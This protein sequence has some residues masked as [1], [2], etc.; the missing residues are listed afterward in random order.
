MTHRVCVK[1]RSRDHSRIVDAECSASLKSPVSSEPT[2]AYACTRHIE[3]YYCAACSPREAMQY[4][5]LVDIQ[6]NNFAGGVDS[7]RVGTLKVGRAHVRRIE[8][9]KGAVS[10]AHKAMCH[11]AGVEVH[12]RN[13]PSC[14]DAEW[15]SSTV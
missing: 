5:N 2:H 14:V 15:K 7:Q 4:S 13:V 11:A 8:A 1:I 12:S 10:S 3:G 9:G 6:T